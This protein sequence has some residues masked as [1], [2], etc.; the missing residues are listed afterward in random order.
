M[1]VVSASRI[2]ERTT[3]VA[4]PSALADCDHITKD[5]RQLLLHAIA[6]K[7]IIG[8]YFGSHL[9]HLIVSNESE[10]PKLTI[11]KLSTATATLAI[12]V[13]TAANAGADA[14]KETVTLRGKNKKNHRRG[15]LHVPEPKADPKA[16]PPPPKDP[17]A[18]P[19]PPPKDPKA[20]PSPPKDP[21]A[22]PPH[23]DELT[24][25]AK[26]PGPKEEKAMKG[27][28]AGARAA[29]LDLLSRLSHSSVAYS[30]GRGYAC[31]FDSTGLGGPDDPLADPLSNTYFDRVAD[32]D[33]L[34]DCQDLCTAEPWCVG[35]EYG[36]SNKRCELWRADIGH[37]AERDSK[38]GCFRK[39]QGSD[40]AVCRVSS[41][42][43]V[44][45]R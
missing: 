14:K 30:G 24:P 27:F 33:S 26:G 34:E 38:W 15:L 6:P 42:D 20:G 9:F 22:L 1:H 29:N 32:Q 17:K 45:P 43:L 18:G 4:L 13:L 44:L 2:C 16:G 8:Q 12:A 3:H 35:V 39:F 31:R 19:P 7:I 36:F 28:E 21:K 5:F 40:D 25:K 10:K 37:Y 23:K 41:A 11:M